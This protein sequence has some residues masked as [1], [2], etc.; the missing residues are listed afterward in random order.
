MFWKGRKEMDKIID[1][2]VSFI[3]NEDVAAFVKELLTFFADMFK[4]NDADVA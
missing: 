4:K 2:I 3:K 1:K